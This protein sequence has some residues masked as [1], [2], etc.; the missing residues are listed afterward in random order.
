MAASTPASAF[1]PHV[2]PPT[3]IALRFPVLS[4]DEV[5]LVVYDWS[6]KKQCETTCFRA[7]ADDLEVSLLRTIR[8]LHPAPD[9]EPSPHLRLA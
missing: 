8:E 4:D 3:D 1:A 7:D 5:R 2:V 9:P 6:G